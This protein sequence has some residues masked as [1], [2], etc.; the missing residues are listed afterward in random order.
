MCKVECPCS[1]K[2]LLNAEKFDAEMVTEFQQ[3]PYVFTGTITSFYECYKIL[4]KEGKME[5]LDDMVLKNIQELEN[6]M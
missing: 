3:A 6:R 2:G 1:P 4:T 5:E